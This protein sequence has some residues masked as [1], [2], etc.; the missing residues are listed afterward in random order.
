MPVLLFRCKGKNKVE[1]SN[2][3]WNKLA[4]QDAS[5]MM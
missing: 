4:F 5:I 2:S 3:N 1:K